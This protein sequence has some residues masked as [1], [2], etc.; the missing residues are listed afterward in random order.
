[1]HIFPCVPTTT[2]VSV[3]GSE[4]GDDVPSRAF[5]TSFLLCIVV[6]TGASA[7][8]ARADAIVV[9][10]AMT[11]S[12]IAE[13]FAGEE[14][15]RVELEIG[16]RDLNGFRNIMPDE[17]YERLGHDPTPLA[18]RIPRFFAEDWVIRVDGGEP[19]VGRI[20][21]MEPGR[22]IKR[23]EITGEPL[24]VQPDD[25]EIVV[26]VE[27][28]Y[29]LATR[30]A[31]L[32]IRPPT[33]GDTSFV[34][35]NIG[36]VVYH[37]GLPV[38]DF[39]YL[40]R[41]E[42]LDLD[43]NDPWYSSFR[44]RNLRRQFNAPLS[45]FLY[46]EYLE[47]RKEIVVRPKDL[48]EWIDLGL[49]G[50]RII[51]AAEQEALKQKVAEFLAERGP[52]LVDGQRVEPTL[53]RIHFIRRSLRMTRVID[54]PED[55]DLMSATLGVIF[56][57]PIEGLP[58][59]V[60][61]RWD[62][63]SPRI[64]QVSA[65]A[66][67]EA[68][69]LPYT[70][71]P[72]DP[73]LKWQNFLTNPST[74]AMLAVAQPPAPARLPVFLVSII[75]AG[76]FGASVTAG[77]RRR[78]RDGVFPRLLMAA[79]VIAAAGTVL[80]LPFAR[81]TVAIPFMSPPTLSKKDATD[82]LAGLLNNIYRAFDWRD[83]GVIYDRLALSISGDLLSDVYLQTR[84]SMELEGQGGARVKVDQVDILAADSE[85]VTESG[86]FVYRC[87][88]N[89]SGSVGHWGHI[90]RRT[91]QYEAVFTVEPVENAWKI[92]AIDLREEKRL[93]A[94]AASPTSGA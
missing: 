70:I 61:L 90:H 29:P 43:W 6:W 74:P 86:G 30:P 32:S 91:N 83:E 69:G 45:V 80:G 92:A 63:F 67:D 22:R 77:S 39:R 81:A 17:L 34:G 58:D 7:A 82:V 76:C 52:V 27:F 35:A 50:K 21:R 4:R 53:D 64:Q 62:L 28:L 42:T 59:E 23:D 56:V 71:T 94:G 5:P 54:P 68:G 57:Y 48:Q 47:I 44:N 25:A 19:L 12:T 85:D 1:M 2:I 41:E 75:F 8:R 9:S 89:V 66:T 60:T 78:R 36:F 46:V 10:K 15:I 26:R 33:G 24:L 11:A 55:L 65:A 3:S 87:R 88:W 73:V 38:N 18:E 49:E 84:R 79:C 51:P 14:S 20:E 40:G 31:A 37:L 93:D 16:V 72:D 13:V